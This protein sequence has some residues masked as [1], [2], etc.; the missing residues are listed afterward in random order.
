MNNGKE[1]ASEKKLI[2][3]LK[4]EN[5]KLKST[6]ERKGK[7]EHELNSDLNDLVEE[8][9]LLQLERDEALDKL[10]KLK[11]SNNLYDLIYSNFIIHLSNDLEKTL[12]II[13]SSMKSSGFFIASIPHIENCYQN[14]TYMKYDEIR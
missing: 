5:H 11:L 8:N 4:K 13:Y 10:D 7:V 14:S 2:L 12:K 3:S 9:R 6:L 1:N